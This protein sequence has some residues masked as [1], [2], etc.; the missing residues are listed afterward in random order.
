MGIEEVLTAER[1]SDCQRQL[2]C[3]QASPKQGHQRPGTPTFVTLVQPERNVVTHRK[4][5]PL[6]AR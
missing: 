6:F 2:P 4:A 3:Y 1:R 5:A